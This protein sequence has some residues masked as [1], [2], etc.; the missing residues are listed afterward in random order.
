MSLIWLGGTCDYCVSPSPIGLDFGTLDFGTSDLGLTNAPKCKKW[1]RASKWTPIKK[2]ISWLYSWLNSDLFRA[3][4]FFC[5]SKM[6][7]FRTASRT[8]VSSNKIQLRPAALAQQALREDIPQTQDHSQAQSVLCTQHY[9]QWSRRRHQGAQWQPG[10]R[11]R[12]SRR[13]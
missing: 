12:W 9:Q 6:A 1:N 4:K 7:D 10:W 2:W 5:T 8:T 11:S 13:T 3:K